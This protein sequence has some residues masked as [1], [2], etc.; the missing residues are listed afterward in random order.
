MKQLLLYVS[1]LLLPLAAAAKYK[2]IIQNKTPQKPDPLHF[3]VSADIC[4][5]FRQPLWQA[6]YITYV[7][8]I[9][10]AGN[11]IRKKKYKPREHH[12][13]IIYLGNGLGI[14]VNQSVF[15]NP[16]YVYN[17]FGN[18]TYKLITTV[19][20]FF[21]YRFQ[22]EFIKKKREITYCPSRWNTRRYPFKY[23]DN[24]YIKASFTSNSIN[25]NYK[26]KNSFYKAK[27]VFSNNNLYYTHNKN[28]Q[29]STKFQHPDFPY[30]AFT[31]AKT[32]KNIKIVPADLS[33]KARKTLKQQDNFFKQKIIGSRL[34]GN[35]I[36]LYF[37]K[38]NKF[39][40]QGRYT[41]LKIFLERKTDN[42][43]LY[44]NQDKES[45]VK[46]TLFKDNTVSI[47]DREENGFI[48]SYSSQGIQIKKI[49]RGR[50]QNIKSYYYAGHLPDD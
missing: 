12:P 47:L 42:L 3:T 18:K 19:K 43:V 7:R 27:L 49:E 46:I 40:R 44:K 38:A 5:S 33:A 8:E 10:P 6:E 20:P 11:L 17:L 48:Y 24:F 29:N 25:Y 32:N 31:L 14:D 41:D 21:K 34:A 23:D 28:R 37:R 36:S 22:G 4:T 9:S 45:L 26:N 13:A 35:K 30:P 2:E 15:F 50:V 1:I 39:T 16:I